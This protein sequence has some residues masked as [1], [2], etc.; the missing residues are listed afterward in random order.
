M[1]IHLHSLCQTSKR[2]ELKFDLQTKGRE[3]DWE[4]PS[5][6]LKKSA[7]VIYAQLGKWKS[8]P[9]QRNRNPRSALP[10]SMNLFCLLL[11]KLA[12]TL[13]SL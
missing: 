10:L 1:E 4:I 13:Q 11:L 9:A 8:L 3:I 7:S 5:T 12:R 2:N 6:N